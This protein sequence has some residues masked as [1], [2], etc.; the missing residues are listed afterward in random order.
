M[1]SLYVDVAL[2]KTKSKKLEIPMLQKNS[3]QFDQKLAILFGLSGTGKT[4]ILMDMVY[5]LK[6]TCPVAFV[7]SAN[8]KQ[9]RDFE[10]VIPKPYI[11]YKVTPEIIKNIYLRQKALS[12]IHAI[13]NNPKVIKSIF[14]ELP[15]T[16]DDK[17][18]VLKIEQK[19]Q[20][21][22]E[23]IDRTDKEFSIKK[24]EKTRVMKTRQRCITAIMK[25]AIRRDQRRISKK[26]PVGS[27]QKIAIDNLNINHRCLI[28]MD[29][30]GS[31]IKKWASKD[32]TIMKFFFEARH[33]G[34][35][36]IYLFQDDK[37]LAPDLRKNAFIKIF[38]SAETARSYFQTANNAV[39]ANLK[40]EAFAAIDKVFEP[41][42]TGG[43]NY[44]KL[45]YLRQC[46]SHPLQYV[47]ADIHDKF[48]FGCDAY[49][50]F[51][52]S[53]EA[54]ISLDRNN[55]FTNLFL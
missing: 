22:I 41:L 1:T 14:D 23:M 28:I 27:E 48:T 9:Q 34:I 50:E 12:E 26:Y 4:T 18:S 31:E 2:S 43:E 21:T 54:D 16:D 29:D 49:Q 7:F 5:H 44:R 19:T 17:Y 37:T 13:A 55:S 40:K 35:T 30:M 52:K 39:G 46:A 3:K 33:V 15:P 38:C 11:Y 47:V 45:V 8:E 32:E 53:I 10:D 36:S 6:D 20:K 42:P 51:G 24:S 25:S